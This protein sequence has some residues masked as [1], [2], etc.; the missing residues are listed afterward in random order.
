MGF[1]TANSFSDSLEVLPKG[2]RDKVGVAQTKFNANRNQP[3]L[4]FEKIHAADNDIYS[5]R[6]N[7]DYRIICKCPDG[8]T[9][10]M[11]YV[12]KHDDAYQWAKTHTT[13]EDVNGAMSV[14]TAVE[15]RVTTVAGRPR[16]RFNAFSDADFEAINVPTEYREELRARVFTKNSLF[17]YRDYL[18]EETYFILEY[19]LEGASREDALSFYSEL[20]EALVP[21]P[22]VQDPPLF[23]YPNSDLAHIGVPVELVDL[24][25]SCRTKESFIQIQDK[26]PESAVQSLYAV[27]D[28]ESIDD[29]KKKKLSESKNTVAGDIKSVLDNASTKQSIVEIKT[30]E[31]FAK[32]LEMPM[33]KWRLF[34]HPDQRHIVEADYNGPARVIGG[35]GTGKT[36]IVVHRAKELASRCRNDDRVLVTTYSRTLADDISARLESICTKAE[37]GRIDVNTLDS[38]TIPLSPRYIK[39][40]RKERGYSA[41]PLAV[42]WRNAQEKANYYTFPESFYISEWSEIIQGQQIKSREAYLKALRVGR[43]D[44]RVDRAAR[45]K[46]YTVMEYYKE[47]MI[48]KNWID[49]DWAENECAALLSKNNKGKYKFVIVDECQD[50]RAPAF[51]LIRAL[52]GKEHPNDL[53]LAGDSRQRIYSGRAS[54]SSCGIYVRNRSTQLKVNYRTTREIYDLSLKLQKGFNYDDLDNNPTEKDGNSS[55]RHGEPP[56]IRVFKTEGEEISAVIKDIKSRL[57]KGFRSSEI[58]IVAKT[59]KICDRYQRELMS[60]GLEPL[61]LLQDQSDDRTLP[62][63]RVSTMHRVK[64]MEFDCIY[65]VSVNDGVMPFNWEHKDPNK[66]KNAQLDIL[67]KDA[68]L[69]AVAIT[70]ARKTSWISSFGKPS[71]LLDKVLD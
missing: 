12:G 62:G 9:N 53:F 57:K 47:Y 18:S 65:A 69:L 10:I 21:T 17:G 45:D 8:D 71:V 33:E 63:I 42:A 51:R 54:L 28:G 6:V 36:V 2:I 58:C 11:L 1:Y 40:N 50:F 38:I 61:R 27:L 3:G 20:M 24:V 30:D 66:D 43:G 70:R 34:L 13:S 60:N 19:V 49:I 39:Y 31:E 32:L 14:Y 35:A 44:H 59:N 5:I 7:D 64:G 15:P 46:I 68:N 23:D 56:T 41:S 48:E 26:L 52:A 4:N 16:S 37:L 29:I 25:K 67:K 22:K 55:I